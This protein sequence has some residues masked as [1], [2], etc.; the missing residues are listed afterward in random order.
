MKTMTEM[1]KL[2]IN[3]TLNVKGAILNAQDMLAVATYYKLA[4]VQ[5]YVFENAKEDLTA[6]EA[7]KIAQLAIEVMDESGYTE[8]DAVNVAREKLGYKKAFFA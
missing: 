2:L 6:E 4:R 3:S 7:K 5:E 1:N 8:N